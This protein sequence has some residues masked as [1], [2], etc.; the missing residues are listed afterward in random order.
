MN[1]LLEK[2]ISRLIGVGAAGFLINIVLSEL[3]FIL[4]SR[5][6]LQLIHN[7]SRREKSHVVN[8]LWCKQTESPNKNDSFHNQN[9]IDS[10]CKH[11]ERGAR[12]NHFI[13]TSVGLIW[14]LAPRTAEVSRAVDL[15]KE[16]W[17]Q[18]RRPR[19]FLWKLL[20]DALSQKPPSQV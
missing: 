10:A 4:N 12:S 14:K 20:S 1:W 16:T 2:I 11:F 19:W 13:P 15:L 9:F 6:Y 5:I 8:N 18:R 3:I 7:R 17:M